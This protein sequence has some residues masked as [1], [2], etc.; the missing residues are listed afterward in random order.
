MEAALIKKAEAETKKITAQEAAAERKLVAEQV[1]LAAQELA[2][3]RK[4]EVETRKAAAAQA[5]QIAQDE[6]ATRKAAAALK[7]AEAAAGK[8]HWHHL[9]Q[10]GLSQT[11]KS[12]RL[13]Q[14]NKWKPPL[15]S[16]AVRTTGFHG[17][18]AGR[19]LSPAEMATTVLFADDFRMGVG[20]L[21]SQSTASQIQVLHRRAL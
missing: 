14:F 11:R 10:C 12:K 17:V 3:A 4:A 15:I 19:E 16:A 18:E 13:A 2:A 21:G 20:C 6:A 9:S 8:P 1:K 5:K 7:K